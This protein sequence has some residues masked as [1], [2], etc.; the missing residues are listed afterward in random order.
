MPTLTITGL[1]DKI[2]G[3]NL[4]TVTFTFSEDVTGFEAADVTVTGG[5]KGAFTT[6]NAR[7][8]TLAVTPS[9]NADVEVSVPA[10]AATDGVNDGPVSAVTATAVWDAVVPTLTIT[11]LPDK[12]NGRNLLTVTF[13][14]SEDVTGFEAADVTVTGGSKGAFTTTNA[15]TYTLA[16]TPSGNADVEVSVPA[17]AA[18]DGVN[19]GP[20][21]AVTATAVWDAVVPTLTITGLPDKINGRDL[22]TVTFTFNEDVT[23][24][25]TED[26]TVTGGAKGTFSG[27][28]AEY[29]LGITPDDGE[30]VVVSVPADAATDG[31]NDGP[32]SAVTATAVWDAVVPTLTITGLPDKINGRDL[33]TATFTFNEDVTGFEAADV[34]VS[35]GSKG[36]FTT[37]NARTYTLAVTPSG[38]ADVEVSVPANAATDGANQTPASRV[39]ATAVWDAAVPTLTITGLPDKINGRDL[40]TVTFTFSEDVTGFEAADVT[41]SGGSK[42]AFTTTNAR[43]YTLAVTPSGNADVEVSVPANAATDGANQTP[44]S[45]VSATAVWDAAVPTLTITGVPSRINSTSAF[46]ATFTFSEAVTGFEVA[47]VAVSGGSKGAFTATNARTYML[48]ITP[49]GNADIVVSVAAEVAT[50]GI[51]LAPASVVEARAVWDSVVPILAITDVPAKINTRAAFTATLRFS[52]DVT[53]F[54]AEDVT[55]SGGSKGTFSATNA[56]TYTLAITPAGNADVVVNVAAEVATDGINLA[57][58][59]S[60]EAIA[61]WDTEAPTLAITGLPGKING[62]DL[63]TATFTFSEDVT[64]FVTGDVT[65]TGGSKGTFTATGPRSYALGVTPAGNENVVVS[66]EAEVTTDGINLGPVSRVSATALWDADAPTVAITDVPARINTGG[67]FTATFTFSEAVTGFETGDVT[68]TGGTKGVFTGSGTTYS[69]GITPVAGSDIMIEVAANSVTD[70]LNSGPISAVT[71]TAIWGA[72]S[73]TVADAVATEGDALMFTVVLDERVSG[74]LMVTPNFTDSTATKGTDY[75]ENTAALTFTGTA[76]ETQ[77]FTVA[78]IEDEL[79][80]ADEIFMV[81]LTVS[82]TTEVVEAT[83]TGTGTITD[84]DG[85]SLPA[86]SFASQSVS[87]QEDAG[88]VNVMVQVNPVSSSEFMLNYQVTGTATE[89]EDYNMVRSVSVTANTA[90]VNIPVV[91]NDDHEDE[92][93]ETVIVTLTRS[94][95]HAVG[96][97]QVYTLT[98]QDNDA[99]VVLSASPNPVSEG[100]AVEVMATLSQT[101]SREVRI[102][103][104]LSSATAAVGD[105]GELDSIVVDKNEWSGTGTIVTMKDSDLNDEIFTVALGVLPP[106]ILAGTPASVEVTITDAGEMTSVESLGDESPTV[107]LAQNYPNPFN[108]TTAIEFSLDKTQRVT[109]MVYD[110][111]GQEV[112]TLVD[113]VQS[114]GRHSILFAGS[115]LASDTYIYVLQTEG[116]RAV[117]MMTLLK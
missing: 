102:P 10:N 36:A 57:P 7:T 52:G 15:R 96:S 89:S 3:R 69:L 18:T 33:L 63:L 104:V 103:L 39:S 42:G 5:S 100:E 19:D 97:V 79:V 34:T 31:V 44:A 55:V 76:G 53:G 61:I 46:T 90:S 70:G 51:N 37:T 27:S 30:D 113:G 74:G 38:N 2:N 4:L 14:F 16:V 73:V 105:Y 108:P 23:G 29:T 91:I 82:G 87:V 93:D 60:V 64:G 75:T 12:I 88:T 85:E 13:T 101:I 116:Q 22:L 94:I 111:L 92:K 50:D 59:S 8:Y 107:V 35:G 49:S 43:T 65:V 54:A 21:S 58:T 106:G 72:V 25:V 40:L 77:T 95:G 11:G 83:D 68:V 115:G 32:V 45:Q 80:E 66:V 98:I 114:A 117:K 24:F 1:P 78:T 9:G 109:L 17:N 62:R 86:V 48:A 26:V 47:D 84:D 56:Q 6:T 41:V 81:G 71:E 20:V 67:V 110:I 99:T 112:R 28:D